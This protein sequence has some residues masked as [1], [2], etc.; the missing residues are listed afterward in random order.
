M[1][2]ESQIQ[3]GIELFNAGQFFEAHEAWEEVWLAEREPEKTFLQGLIQIAAAFHHRQRGNREGMESLLKAGLAKL[4]RF[5]DSH[6]GIAV[7]R[8]RE[9]AKACEKRGAFPQIVTSG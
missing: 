9:D 2:N 3:R 8:L 4:S 1:G 7:E 6:R 5:P